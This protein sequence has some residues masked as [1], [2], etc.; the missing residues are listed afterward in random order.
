MEKTFLENYSLIPDPSNPQAWNR[1]S[2]VGNNP[3]NFNDPT[4]HKECDDEKGCGGT[5]PK[6]KPNS[7]PKPKAR[8]PKDDGEPS[9]K[10]VTCKAFNGDVGAILDLLI[11]THF[12]WRGQLEVGVTPNPAFSLGPSGT[13]GV[14]IAYNRFSGELGAFVDWTTEVGGSTG[15]PVGASFTEV[16]IIGWGSSTI[17]DVAKGDSAIVSGTAAYKG[18]ISAS[19]SVP[20][21]GS[22]GMPFEGFKLHVDPVYGQIP[23]TA[24][25]GGGVGYAYGSLGGGATHVFAY[26]IIDLAP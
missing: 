19:I 18:A 21:E 1:Y 6:L 4:G 8:L 13:L 10:T 5:T 25:G 2:Y 16:P 26:S 23:S 20:F 12:G 11:P 24:Y 17:K 3:V 22:I 14:N 15:T 7:N 9:C